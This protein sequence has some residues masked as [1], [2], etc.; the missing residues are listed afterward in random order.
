M[1]TRRDGFTLIELLVVIA[2]IGILAGLLLPALNRARGRAQNIKCTSNLKGIGQ[3]LALYTDVGTSAKGFPFNFRPLINGG[4]L[5]NDLIQCPVQGQATT[6]TATSSPAGSLAA[7]LGDYEF[8]GSNFASDSAIARD[9][10]GGTGSAANNGHGLN[11]WNFL[12]GDMNYVGN[13]GNWNDLYNSSNA[14]IW[15]RKNN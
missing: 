10:V 5:V 7:D 14:T 15:N 9:A 3:A 2:I 1:K 12:H 8:I 11:K 4:Y 6:H 13:E